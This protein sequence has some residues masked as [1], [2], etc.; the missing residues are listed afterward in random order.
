[1]LLVYRTHHCIM[2]KEFWIAS[3]TPSQE[4]FA[5]SSVSS[6]EVVEVLRDPPLSAHLPAGNAQ[7]VSPFPYLLR[8][9]GYDSRGNVPMRLITEGSSRPAP[10]GGGEYREYPNLKIHH[11]LMVMPGL[12]F[13]VF[14]PDPA[15]RTGPTRKGC[16]GRDPVEPTPQP[17]QGILSG[18]PGF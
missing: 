14:A 3:R 1:M 9:L 17:T 6:R 7:C 12:Q 2:C 8:N 11:I 13:G 18:I 5:S 4:S 16:F 15:F 10:P